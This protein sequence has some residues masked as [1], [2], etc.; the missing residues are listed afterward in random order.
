MII[1]EAL[2]LSQSDLEPIIER[3][4]NI[5]DVIVVILVVCGLILGSSLFR[6]FRK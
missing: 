5:I 6:H 3:L 2:Q 4:D 1:T